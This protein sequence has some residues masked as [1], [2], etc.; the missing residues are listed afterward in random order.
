[1]SRAYAESFAR[2]IPGARLATIADAGHFPHIEQPT[3]LVE[4]IVRFADE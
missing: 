1:V 2:L 4:S 3:A